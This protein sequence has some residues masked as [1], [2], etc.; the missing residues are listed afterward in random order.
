MGLWS[1][2]PARHPRE[3]MLH[4][5]DVKAIYDAKWS[6]VYPRKD[7]IYAWSYSRNAVHLIYPEYSEIPKDRFGHWDS[8][9]AKQR[10]IL[11]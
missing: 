2:N 5:Q 8:W 11:E 6:R 9:T 7:V 3:S 10:V 1:A 4:Q